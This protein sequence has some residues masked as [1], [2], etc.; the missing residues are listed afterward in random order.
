MIKV[1]KFV[2]NPFLENTYIVWDEKS[3]EAAIIDPGCYDKKEETEL[4]NFI[5]EQKLNPIFIINTH[6]HID[7][8]FGNAFI[9]KKYNSK[10]LAPEEDLFLFD[11]MKQE[12]EKFGYNFTRSPLPDEYISEEKPIVL[13]NIKG[14]FLFTPGHTPGEHCLYFED[15]K[16]CFTGDV[17]FQESIG[18]TDLWG[19]NYEILLKSI[20]TKL[21]T[22]PDDVRI[23]PGHESDS[24][25]G[26]EKKFNPF[27]IDL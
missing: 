23:F 25:I 2:F 27:L 21:L 15:D 9:K 20:K 13:G 18:R 4:A 5:E 3:K 7:H 26:R 10:L 19:G 17:L 16:L 24:T 6:C 14:V 12:A 8:I 1:H 11:L 22:L